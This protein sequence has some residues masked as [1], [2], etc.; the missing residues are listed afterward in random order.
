[1]PCWI[2][3]FDKPGTEVPGRIDA[4]LGYKRDG[5]T[6]FRQPIRRCS[7]MEYNVAQA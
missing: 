4:L 2:A 3:A 1:M 7:R 5:P 6:L